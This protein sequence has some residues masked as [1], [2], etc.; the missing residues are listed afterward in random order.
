MHKV[1]V[2]AIPLPGIVFVVVAYVCGFGFFLFFF[3]QYTHIYQECIRQFTA[4]FIIATNW[5]QLKCLHRI[6]AT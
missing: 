3:H 6:L 1:F 2:L 4:L 5:K